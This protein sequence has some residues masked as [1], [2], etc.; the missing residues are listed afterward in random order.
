MEPKETA[1]IIDVKVG[2]GHTEFDD[3]II[4]NFH[5]AMDEL[6]WYETIDYTSLSSIDA[7]VNKTPSFENI[8]FPIFDRD[9]YIQLNDIFS[10]DVY[11]P[12]AIKT[13]ERHR[14]IME[15]WTIHILNNI[16]LL[17]HDARQLCKQFFFRTPEA[18]LKFLQLFRGTTEKKRVRIQLGD[19]ETHDTKK[20]NLLSVVSHSF[21]KRNRRS[22]LS[23][24]N[25]E[26]INSKKGGSKS[27]AQTASVRS[28]DRKSI[29]DVMKKMTRSV[30]DSKEDRED[31]ELQRLSELNKT[32][33]LKIEVQRGQELKAGVLLYDITLKVV[34]KKFKNPVVHTTHQRYSKFRLLW[35]KLIEC[36]EQ[37]SNSVE[38]T[39][40]STPYAHFMRLIHSPFPDLT[41]KS[42]LM[43]P[44]NDTELSERTRMLDAWFRDVCYYYRH[45]PATARLL[46]RQFLNFDMSAEKDILVQD[47]LAWGVIEVNNHEAPVLIIQKSAI[48]SMGGN[49]A[50]MDT[51]SEYSSDLR[52]DK[53]NSNGRKSFSRRA[54]AK[55]MGSRK[56]SRDISYDENDSEDRLQNAIWETASTNR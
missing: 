24:Q 32:T 48:D 7:L 1:A 26:R 46:I 25:L 23:K 2:W 55:S 20:M 17:D 15:M 47:Q 43:L 56:S 19:G 14:V 44:L 18:V 9:D 29:F 21:F 51:M 3:V 16:S 42:Y 52:A 49:D 45:M 8:P 22:G 54:S 38:V 33:V 40:S 11:D 53:N 35:K 6:E 50:L 5:L 27:G 13:L 30:D 28:A 37:W 4:F 10:S 31:D 34:G 41:M 39:N 12:E 36:N